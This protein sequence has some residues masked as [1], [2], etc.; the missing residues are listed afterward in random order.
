[1]GNETV[2]VGVGLWVHKT[3]LAIGHLHDIQNAGFDYLL[4]KIADGSQGA[5]TYHLDDAAIIEKDAATINLP[6]AYWAYVTPDN[7]SGQINAI[8]E[9]L[10][11]D[12]ADLVLDAEVEWENAPAKIG[13][14]ETINRVHALCRG[15]LSNR[16]DLN[17]HLSSFWSTKLHASL[18]F[19]TFAQHCA[20][21]EPQCYLEP[22]SNRSASDILTNSLLEYKAAGSVTIIPTINRGEFL[23]LLKARGITN[24]NIYCWDDDGDAE[25]SVNLQP[26]EDKIKAFKA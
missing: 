18:P 16:P 25:V 23:P 24:T 21:L 19:R 6:V 3:S 1:M 11:D 26:W 12:A 8:L 17:L 2:L 22:A 10:P 7:I 5:N 15:L 14:V 13:T 20:T 4:I 9:G